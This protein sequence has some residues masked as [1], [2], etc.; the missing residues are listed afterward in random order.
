MPK[1]VGF[2]W[3]KMVTV[4]NCILA[5]RVMRRNKPHNHTARHIA[6]N[7]EKY[8]KTLQEKIAGGSYTFSEPRKKTIQD[9]YKGKT[10]NLMIPCLEDQ[11]AMQAWLNIATPYILKKNYYY[12]CG[13]IPGAGQARAINGLKRMMTGRKP[14]KWAAVTDIRK[15]Y[16]TCS[17]EA[18]LKGLRR[19]FKDEKFIDFAK[20]M[21]DSMSDN[22]VGLAIGY[23]VSHWFANIAL[24]QVDLNLR[25][26]FPDMR[27]FR[28][29]DDTVFAGNNKRH[30][31]WAVWYY[32]ECVRAMGMRVKS[33]WQMFPT[34]KRGILFLSYRFFPGYTLLAKPLMYRISRKM[35]RAV[36]Q[37]SVHTAMSM[38]SYMGILKQ[39]DSQNFKLVHVYPYISPK[40]C[41]RLISN[42]S[43]NALCRAT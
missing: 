37:M 28:Y 20:Q 43:K 39:F 18:V 4:E 12:N 27:H 22:G 24:M 2:L 31:R 13:S 34:K 29:M 19:I 41:R 38:I 1:R 5:E 10:R 9:S 21:M 3:E 11:A 25:R 30:I 33:T 16:D 17:H 15:F 6:Q 35:R 26:K 23:P 7:P 8:G 36:R 40:K 14:P 42:E 32:S